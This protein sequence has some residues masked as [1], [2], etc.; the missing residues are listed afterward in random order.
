[1]ETFPA[2][3]ALCAGNSPVTGLFPTQR[4]VTRSFDVFFN[5]RVS[6]RL[7]T[8]S[9]GW[10]FETPSSSLWRHICVT[11]PQWVKCS[12]EGI[13]FLDKKQIQWGH[14]NITISSYQSKGSHFQDKTVSRQIYLYNG[15][16]HTWVDRLYFETRPRCVKSGFR[17]IIAWADTKWWV[18]LAN[19][20]F[21]NSAVFI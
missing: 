15:N 17:L 11:R 13:T 12:T 10:W 3:L 2:L 5:L 14:L 6:K 18:Y 1:M 4:P 20:Y 8:Q 16:L 9:W 21:A 7:S 19:Q